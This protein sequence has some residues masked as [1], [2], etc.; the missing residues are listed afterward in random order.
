MTIAM[1]I[2][3]TTMMMVMTM[4][5]TTQGVQSNGCRWK[6]KFIQNNEN[7]LYAKSYVA[8]VW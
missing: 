8:N 4:T 3:M 2:M 1:M 6:T 5:E 7:Q